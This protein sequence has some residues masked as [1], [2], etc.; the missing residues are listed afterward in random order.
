[1]STLSAVPYNDLNLHRNTWIHDPNCTPPLDRPARRL[2]ARLSNI[3]MIK[4]QDKLASLV[5]Q[6]KEPG[7][8]Y[9]LLMD[10]EIEECKQDDD[11]ELMLAGMQ[12]YKI[13]KATKINQFWSAL[14][15]LNF[16]L[17]TSR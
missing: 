11:P 4:N 5:T 15:F 1:M 9:T 14:F 3:N 13:D 12:C 16:A 8:S 2:L 10:K 17:Q 7:T 6:I